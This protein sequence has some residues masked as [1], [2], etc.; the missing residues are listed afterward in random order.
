[1]NQYKSSLGPYN[2]DYF[3][4]L[5]TSIILCQLFNLEQYQNTEFNLEI[6]PTTKTDDNEITIHSNRKIN[7]SI[8]R[9]LQRK[10]D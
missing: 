8:K 5:V 10:S 4:T 3:K 9:V 1:M 6:K 2:P 7:Y